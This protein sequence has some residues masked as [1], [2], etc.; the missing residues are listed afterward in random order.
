MPR[1]EGRDRLAAKIEDLLPVDAQDRIALLEVLD[2]LAE[3]QR[4]YVAIGRVIAAGPSAL[5]RLALR[6]LLAPGLEAVG[7]LIVDRVDKLLQS[8]LA[9]A[10]E[11]DIDLAGGTAEL[12]GIELDAR[13]L[14]ILVE[15]LRQRL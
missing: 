12:L 1:R 7:G 3:P 10:H 6:Q 8:D 2:L 15:A 9:V 11:R 5:C 4:M 13:E 14:R